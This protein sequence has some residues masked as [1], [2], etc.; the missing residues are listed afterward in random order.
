MSA[1]KKKLDT[2]QVASDLSESA[3]FQ[4]QVHKTTCGEVHNPPATLDDQGYQGFC[5]CAR[6]EGL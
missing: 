6:S 5:G 4:P 2:D 3:F 1:A